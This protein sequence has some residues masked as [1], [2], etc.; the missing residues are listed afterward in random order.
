MCDPV[1]I[2]GEESD[3]LSPGNLPAVGLPAVTTK[4]CPLWGQNVIVLF[5]SSRSDVLD[6]FAF[7]ERVNLAVDGDWIF[8]MFWNAA[9]FW[10][11]S[12]FGR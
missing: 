7:L 2:G 11:V 5:I 9:L 12:T 4:V 10:G 6:R 1:G 3:L 8:W